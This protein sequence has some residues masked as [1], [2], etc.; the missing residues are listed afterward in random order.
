[1]GSQ[2]A[3]AY[4]VGRIVI[5]GQEGPRYFDMD[6]DGALNG[7]ASVQVTY[8]DSHVFL[9]VASVPEYFKSYQNYPYQVKITRGEIEGTTPI[10]CEDK[11]KTKK[12][13]R[14]QKKGRCSK[15]GV[16][17]KCKKTCGLC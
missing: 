17:S 9:V 4:F 3:P 12:C 13:E 15:K 16:K 1:M 7:E 5:L 11:M 8:D 2:G 14:K 10:P 6:M